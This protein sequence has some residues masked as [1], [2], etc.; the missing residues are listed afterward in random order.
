MISKW[1]RFKPN[2]KIKF[3]L[4]KGRKILESVNAR[5]QVNCR[6]TPQFIVI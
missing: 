1:T 3:A 5:R 4:E 6:G 2:E